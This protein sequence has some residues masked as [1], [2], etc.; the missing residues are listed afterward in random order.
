M[1]AATS[2]TV[3]ARRMLGFG[4]VANDRTFPLRGFFRGLQ[5]VWDPEGKIWWFP[6][7]AAK[8]KAIEAVQK[9]PA[10]AK[11]GRFVPRR[12]TAAAAQAGALP[13]QDSNRPIGK[14]LGCGGQVRYIVSKSMAYRK[15]MLCGQDGTGGHA[16]PQ[17]VNDLDDDA[18]SLRSEMEMADIEVAGDRAQ[19]IR[20]ESN[21]AAARKALENAVATKVCSDCKGCGRWR[22][23]TSPSGCWSC[24][25]VRVIKGKEPKN[26]QLWEGGD[27]K[28]CSALDEWVTKSRGEC[29]D[30]A[31]RKGGEF[32]SF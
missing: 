20:D 28:R 25:K 29:R 14:H 24:G 15:C 11:K 9:A 1:M 6:D 5:G 23:G 13:V 12:E 17:L 18:D 21:K 22:A 26:L 31:T 10:P 3:V 8:N 4:V 19:T 16:S 27:C 32:A 7:L 2:S 30:C